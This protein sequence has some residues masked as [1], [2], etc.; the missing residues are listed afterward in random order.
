MGLSGNKRRDPD[1]GRRKMA[2][3]EAQLL[4]GV[5]LIG[6]RVSVP[7]CM[8]WECRLRGRAG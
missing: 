8:L 6:K 1:P 3:T 4:L 7:G 2:E 5:G